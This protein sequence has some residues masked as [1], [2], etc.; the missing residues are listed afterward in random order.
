MEELLCLETIRFGRKAVDN[1]YLIK[2]PYSSPPPYEM[3]RQKE[4]FAL[5]ALWVRQLLVRMKSIPAQNKLNFINGDICTSAVKVAK[6][7]FDLNSIDDYIKDTI[8]YNFP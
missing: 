1:P 2:W 7:F 8:E 5:Q 3:M 6:E 4:P